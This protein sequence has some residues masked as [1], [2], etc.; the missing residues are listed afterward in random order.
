MKILSVS[1]E[2]FMWL[3]IFPIGDKT[4]Q[5]KQLMYNMFGWLALLIDGSGIVSG[6]VRAINYGTAD[7]N[8]ALEALFPA[9]GC[10][11][12]FVALISMIVFRQ[13]VTML[14]ENLQKFHDQSKLISIR[15]PIELSK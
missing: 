10:L 1:R 5:R 7:L 15:I 11:R 2:L 4:N 6:S 12:V 8:N 3:G 9:I 14:F 13:K